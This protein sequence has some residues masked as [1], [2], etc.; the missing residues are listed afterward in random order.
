MAAAAAEEIDYESDPEEAKLL[1]KMR[2][3]AEASDDE[4]EN[5]GEI[6]EKPPRGVETDDSDGA[7]EG[8]AAEYEEDYDL[9][10]YVEEVEEANDDEESGSVKEFAAVVGIGDAGEDGGLPEE[11]E[12]TRVKSDTGGINEDNLNIE[13]REPEGEKKEM[14]PYSVPTAGAFYMHD[15]RFRDSAGGRN[16]Q[17]LGGR[18]LWESKDD[19]KWG[20]DKFEEL[21]L[22]GRTRVEHRSG[23]RGRNRGRGRNRFAQENRP[24][25]LTSNGTQH[26]NNQDSAPKSF[27]GRGPRRYQP[28]SKNKEPLTHVKQQSWKSKEKASYVGSEKTSESTSSLGPDTVL[29]R[30][31]ILASSLNIASPPFYPSGS[32]TKGNSGPKNGDFQAGA[33][34]RRSQPSAVSLDKLYID[35]SLSVTAGKSANTVPVPSSSPT[36]NSGRGIRVAPQNQVNGVNSVNQLQAVQGKHSQSRAQPSARFTP[37]GSRASSPPK[38]SK[39]GNAVEPLEAESNRSKTAWVPK[40]QVITHGS[41]RGSFLYGAAHVTGA[42]GNIGSGHGDPNF[43]AFLPGSVW[44]ILASSCFEMPILFWLVTGAVNVLLVMQFGGQH[45]GGIGVPAVGMAFPGYVGQPQLGRGS[46][47][48][49]WLP[50][51]TGPAGAMGARY[52]PAFAVDGSYEGRSSGQISSVNSASSNLF[53]VEWMRFLHVTYFLSVTNSKPKYSYFSKE[54]NTTNVGGV[55]ESA[56]KPEA[57]ESSQASGFSLMQHTDKIEIPSTDEVMVDLQIYRDEILTSEL[58][59]KPDYFRNS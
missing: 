42:S 6:V 25:E 50:I 55:M 39:A 7:S 12:E 9:D 29:P 41:G 34:N 22:P 47:E 40:G 27:R 17:M 59:A 15:D 56:Q 35:D 16:R 30:K 57:K 11:E 24:R 14:E 33:F 23:P 4:A 48:M 49:T 44:R 31:Q 52:G 45:P 2:R 54:Q 28:S 3:R 1:V 38:T 26:N 32:S 36:M 19:R 46:S 43:P 18:T 58:F 10:E 21:T 20:H 51:L 8:A 53:L 13:D 37:H 5:G